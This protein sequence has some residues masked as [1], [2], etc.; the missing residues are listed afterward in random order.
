MTQSYVSET[1]SFLA[2]CGSNLC[3]LNSIFSSFLWL[4]SNLMKLN[5]GTGADGEEESSVDSHCR[6]E[7]WV[8]WE[9]K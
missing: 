8:H 2:F 6:A 4:N 9:V 1:Q 7:H 3:Q 5:P